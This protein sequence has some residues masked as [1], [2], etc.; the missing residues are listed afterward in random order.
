MA[1]GPCGKLFKVAFS[2]FRY[3]MEDVKGSDCVDQFRAM[4][5]CMQKYPYPEEKPGDGLEETAA[6][7][8]T[9]VIEEEGSS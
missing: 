7:E 6:S 2:C 4:Q 9:A 1:S 8:A 5:G 3:S